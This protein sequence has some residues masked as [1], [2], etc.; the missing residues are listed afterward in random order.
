M[1]LSISA[2]SGQEK[3][4]EEERSA[5][6]ALEERTIADDFKSRINWEDGYI[7]V[8]AGGT[9]N[10]ETA[11]SK[12]QCYAMAL[13]TGRH[14]AL[15]KMAEIIYGVRIDANNVF[16]NEVEADVKLETSTQGLIKGAREIALEQTEFE[17]GSVWVEVTMGL[18]LT[19]D[20]GL[21]SVVVPWMERQATN[22]PPKLFASTVTR[23]P[24]V[25]EATGLIVD[26]TG[27]GLRP[28]MAPRIVVEGKDEELYGRANIERSAA[29]RFGV[30]G[31][32]DEVA[33]ARSLTERVGE[34]P[35]VIRAASVAG[36]HGADVVLTPEEAAK[37]VA[38]DMKGGFLKECRVVFVVG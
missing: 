5:R 26:A 34:N 37:V 23:P 13:K 6:M 14:L 38:A 4:W 7:E 18:L 17:D 31:Y 19:G 8:V 28:A 22:T 16:E 36:T 30:V 33:K 27:L 2:A 3:W 15:E 21:S 32:T 9:C 12:A 10:V 1:L 20:K 24:D 25:P 35:M 29:I 11:K